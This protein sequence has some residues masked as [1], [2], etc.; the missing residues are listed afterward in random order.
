MSR[1]MIRRNKDSEA[2]SG[3]TLVEVVV[4]L[5]LA[6]MILSLT[7]MVLGFGMRTHLRMMTVSQAGHVANQILDK[8]ASEIALANL[9]ADGTEG[10]Y[11]CLA[12]D[13]ASGWVVFQNRHGTPIAVYAMTEVQGNGIYIRYYRSDEMKNDSSGEEIW[14]FD[15]DFYMGFEVE[16]LSFSREDPVHHPNVLRIDLTVTDSRTGISH[17]AYRYVE[18]YEEDAAAVFICVLGDGSKYPPED[19]SDFQIPEGGDIPL[20]SD[21]PL[22]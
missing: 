3:V 11:F 2:V 12:N 6:G 15:D 19:A 13:D 14:T 7:S 9:P 17:D 16:K 1:R 5:A 10:Y 22:T 8:V 21:L 4:V 18:I 20:I